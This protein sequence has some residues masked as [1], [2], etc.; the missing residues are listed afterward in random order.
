MLLITEGQT[1][2]GPEREVFQKDFL[3]L[4]GGIVRMLIPIAMFAKAEDM[5]EPS[6]DLSILAI[7]LL[8]EPELQSDAV[9]LLDILTRHKLPFDVFAKLV[10]VIPRLSS[11]L[12][13][14]VP[15]A[16]SGGESLPIDAY[17]SLTFQRSDFYLRSF[18][19]K[20]VSCG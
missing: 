2:Y 20:K 19:E 9:E 5:C 7:Q 11:S 17:E 18:S 8:C 16:T 6:R 13:Q 14:P 4:M 15:P 1:P 10:D 3:R 12:L